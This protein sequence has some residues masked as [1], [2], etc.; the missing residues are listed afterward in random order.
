METTAL[1]YATTR[2]ICTDKNSHLDWCTVIIITGFMCD[3][4]AKVYEI[5]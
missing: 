2:K 4:T 3:I 1:E 5:I